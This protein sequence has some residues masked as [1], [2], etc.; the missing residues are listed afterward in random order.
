MALSLDAVSAECGGTVAGTASWPGGGPAE[1]SLHWTT[2]GDGSVDAGTAQ[3][4][5]LA[6][7]ERRFELAVPQDGP[8]TFAGKLISVRWEVT[9]RTGD[10]SESAEV[11]VLPRGGLTVWVRNAAPPPQG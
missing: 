4:V 11:T 9:L 3:T 7:G 10:A 5:Q 6:E 2:S 1:M 8:M